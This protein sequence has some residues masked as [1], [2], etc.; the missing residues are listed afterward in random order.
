VPAKRRLGKGLG[1]L[2]PEVDPLRTGAAEGVQSLRLSDI[3]PN[4]HQPRQEFDPERLQELADSMREHG[5]VQPVL[6]RRSSAGYYELVAGERRW[7]AAQIAGLSHIPAIVRD[8]DDEAAM[9][10]AL[11]EN[12]QREDLNPID[13]ANA[14][15]LLLDKFGLTQ[16]QLAAKIGKSRPQIA[17]TLRLLS[18]EPEIREMLQA[19]RLSVG[20]AKALLGLAGGEERVQF[21]RRVTQEGLTVRQVE[22]AIRERTASAQG[23][24]GAGRGPRS[25]GDPIVRDLEA[26]LERALGTRVRI[27][28]RGVKGRI[29]IDYYDRD[30]L[31]RI[32]DAILG[33]QGSG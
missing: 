27:K 18:L 8:L 28:G 16:E 5:V 22:A 19:G 17:N 1:A 12:L 26:R 7:R 3:R 31:D 4:P 11:I 10:I 32:L 25:A 6:V 15:R 20:H 9:E 21:A 30:D 13:E 2:L 29:E 24:K 14:Y 33:P 23:G